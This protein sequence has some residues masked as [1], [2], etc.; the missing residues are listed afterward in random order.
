MTLRIAD[1]LLQQVR[2]AGEAAYPAECCGAI[3]GQADGAKRAGNLVPLA[4]RRTDDPHRYLI[5]AEQMRKVERDAKAA[6]WEVLGFYHSHPDHP[7]VP[8][9]FDTVHAWPWYSYVIV[10]V[11]QGH[12]LQVASWV[13][14]PE[15]PRMEPEPLEVESEA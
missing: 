10:Q 7:A 3:V 11:T 5:D 2:R 1:G 8:S 6:G 14:H 12:A 9:E 15:D 4:N 13:L